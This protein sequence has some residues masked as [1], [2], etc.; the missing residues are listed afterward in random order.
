MNL[1][2]NSFDL[3]IKDDL[4]EPCVNAEFI[5][6]RYWAGHLAEGSYPRHASGF[7]SD[8]V[9]IKHASGLPTPVRVAWKTGINLKNDHE[10]SLKNI[11]LSAIDFDEE[12]FSLKE[13]AQ[14]KIVRLEFV[15]KG[16]Y[17]LRYG[18]M[19]ADTMKETSVDI[20]VGQRAGCFSISAPPF[21]DTS[22][23]SITSTGG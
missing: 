6:F 2:I 11:S 21:G 10:G 9:Y 12:V 14:G 13:L 4:P 7:N 20:V 15:L 22:A 19:D 5:V 8:T 3:P 17:C 16:R 1:L 18:W 23:F